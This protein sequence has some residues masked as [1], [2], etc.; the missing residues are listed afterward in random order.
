MTTCWGDCR[1]ERIASQRQHRI[2]M[3]SS[4]SREGGP[5]GQCLAW[6]WMDVMELAGRLAQEHAQELKEVLRLPGEQANQAR[7]QLQALAQAVHHILSTSRSIVDGK[8]G[9]EGC[10][11]MQTVKQEEECPSEKVRCGHGGPCIPSTVRR[12]VLCTRAIASDPCLRVCARTAGG[13]PGW[14]GFGVGW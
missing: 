6:A 8:E 12:L 13:G 9:K 5:G 3:E 14:G 2:F 11:T 10:A 4:S 7:T 1:L